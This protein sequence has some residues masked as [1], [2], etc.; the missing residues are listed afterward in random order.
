MKNL[1]KKIKNYLT[2]IYLEK[3]PVIRERFTKGI[4][5]MI[6]DKD[7]TK[8]SILFYFIIGFTS[9]AIIWG[10]LAK[11]DTVVRANGSVIPAS[12]VQIAQ[13]VFGGV[14]EEISVKR[15]DNVKKR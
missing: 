1:I 5:N 2:N 8:T 12:K 14:I 10:L 3:L 11:I 4:D 6:P 13:A 7:I 15:G 9:I